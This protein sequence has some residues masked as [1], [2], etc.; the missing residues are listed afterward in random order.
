MISRCPI[1]AARRRKK[2]GCLRRQSAEVKAHLDRVRSKSLAP[3]RAAKRKQFVARWVG[4]VKGK[5][6]AE[7]IQYAYKRGYENGHRTGYA[8]GWDDCAKTWGRVA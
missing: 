2:C 1:C 3:A 5:K 6:V 7:A 4:M 8:K